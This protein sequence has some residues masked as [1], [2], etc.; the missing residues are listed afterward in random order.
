MANTKEIRTKIGSVSNTQKITSAMEMVAASKMR[1]VQDNMTLTRPYAENMRKVISHVASGSLE[2]QHPY[3]QQREPKRV[4]YIIIS[5]DRGLCGGLN[6]NLFKKVLE[7]MEQWQAKGVEVETTLIGSKAIS[8]FQ[9]SGNVIAQTSGLGDAPKLEDILGTVNAMLE[10]YD[11][12]KI[13][14]LFLVYNQFVN[15]MVQAPTALQ[16]LPH[17]SD[18]E[19][20]G[21]ARKARRWDYI[22]EQAPRDILSELLHRYI[23]SQ[24]YQGIVESIACEQAARMVAMKA[25]TDNAGQLID[26]LQLVYNKAR[27]AAIT[28]ELSEIVSGAQAV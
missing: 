1:K 26:D 14:S 5:S 16:L 24:V 8:F 22:Y 21:E 13:D 4:A 15:T 6:S 19:A 9:R 17:P 23:E 10:H 7:E 3:L 12:E 28:Q 2:Y 18:T 11:E 25:A 27:Q 20:D